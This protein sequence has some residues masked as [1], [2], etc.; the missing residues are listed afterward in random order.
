MLGGVHVLLAVSFGSVWKT[1]RCHVQ[2]W[3]ARVLSQVSG[4]ILY[5]VICYARQRER[6]LIWQLNK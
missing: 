6:C 5:E 2:K 4:Y 3:K 1:L